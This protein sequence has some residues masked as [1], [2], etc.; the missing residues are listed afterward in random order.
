MQ[1]SIVNRSEVFKTKNIR[2]DA[3]YWHPHFI[4]N[5]ELIRK[6]N[7]VELNEVSSI[8]SGSTPRGANFKS[9]GVPFI[10]AQDFGRGYIDRQSIVYISEEEANDKQADDIKPRDIII[11]IAGT[12]GEIGLSNIRSNFNQNVARIRTKGDVLPE[13]LFSFLRSR[14]GQYQ[15]KRVNTGNIQ[16]YLNT[17]NLYPILVLRLSNSFQLTI[18]EVIK[19]FIYC[20]EISQKNDNDLHEII[21]GELGLPRYQPTHKLTFTKN[22]SDTQKAE[23][24]DAE[25]F[26]PKYDEITDAIKSYKGGWDKLGNLVT[27]KKSV[28]VG[29]EK[30]FSEGVPFTRVSNLT[31]FEITEEKYITEEMYQELR[32]HQP[33]KGEILLTKD[34]TPGIAYHLNEEPKKMIVSSG[35]LRLANTA[36]KLNNETLTSILNSIITKQQAERDAGGSVIQHW[37]PEQIEN[38]LIPILSEP[39]QAQLKEKITES[40][41]LRRKSKRLLAQAVKAVEIAI[42]KDEKTATQWLKEQ[43]ALV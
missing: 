37:R 8:K 15:L 9:I 14:F 2:L 32:Q 7:P 31:P 34:A 22:F 4:E 13:F 21:I 23:R 38:A 6:E 1:Y 28:E 19:D 29:S 39:I 5:E 35:I 24:F 41:N 42:E 10:R 11:S 43:E 30:Y 18:S 27:Y 25:Y 33:K 26:Q 17:G 3:E 12:V 40:F 36:Q 20:S 16:P